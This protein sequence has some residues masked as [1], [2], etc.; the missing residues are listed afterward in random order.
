MVSKPAMNSVATSPIRNSSAI[1]PPGTAPPVIS[2]NRDSNQDMSSFSCHVPN[3]LQQ[4]NTPAYL[5]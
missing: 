4:A 1:G 5:T 2:A 3:T